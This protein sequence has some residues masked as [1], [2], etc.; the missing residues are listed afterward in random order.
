MGGVPITKRGTE[1]Q[2]RHCG[3]ELINL[4]VLEP[5]VGATERTGWTASVVN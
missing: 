2:N 4:F 3:G 1:G 5:L